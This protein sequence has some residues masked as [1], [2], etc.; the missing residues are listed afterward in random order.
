MEGM[1]WKKGDGAAE[2]LECERVSSK[3]GGGKASGGAWTTGSLG[4]TCNHPD[5]VIEAELEIDCGVVDRPSNQ[6][7]KI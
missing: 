4:F 2:T 5:G 1:Q 6:K 7:P 3:G